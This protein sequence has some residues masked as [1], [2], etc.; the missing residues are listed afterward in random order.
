M[1]E[2][3]KWTPGPWVTNRYFRDHIIPAEH[4]GRRVGFATAETVDRDEFA[5][6]IALVR[7]DRHG[8]GDTS[9][10]AALLSAA[11]DMAEALLACL[12]MVEGD[13]LPPNWDMIRAALRKAGAL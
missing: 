7:Q 2:N 6:I 1:T 11:P 3:A 5:Q 9:A 12:N 8:R 13:G 4:Q 10:N